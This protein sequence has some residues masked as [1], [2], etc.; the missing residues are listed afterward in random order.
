MHVT[1]EFEELPF[2]K[3]QDLRRNDRQQRGDLSAGD[4]L[5]VS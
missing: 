3:E 5:T 2:L 4:G 1:Y